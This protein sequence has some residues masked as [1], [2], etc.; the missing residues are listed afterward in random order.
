MSWCLYLLNKREK[1]ALTAGKVS[2]DD[3]YNDFETY[4]KFKAY[5]EEIGDIDLDE[6]R[7]KNITLNQMR[8]FLT[9]FD[10]VQRLSWI[11]TPLFILDYMYYHQEDEFEFK[12]E[13]PNDYIVISLW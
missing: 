6:V 8:H 1:V 11:Q 13:I 4:K 3:V 5:L 2:E 12:T 10:F 7:L 9:A